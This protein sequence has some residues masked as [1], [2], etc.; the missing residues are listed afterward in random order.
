[1]SKQFQKR[2]VI[3]DGCQILFHIMYRRRELY[4]NYE[5]DQRSA[6]WVSEIQLLGSGSGLAFFF[7]GMVC[8]KLVISPDGY[9]QL[10]KEVDSIVPSDKC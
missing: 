7:V 3:H 1:M 6:D 9:P 8:M 2:S 10:L 4:A 5:C